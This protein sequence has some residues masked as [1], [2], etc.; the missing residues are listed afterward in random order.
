MLFF[1]L[2]SAK[3]QYISV[4]DTYT[5]QQ[6]VQNVLLNSGCANVSNFSVSGGNFGAENTYGFFNAGSSGFPLSSGVVLSTCRAKSCEGPNNSL[7]SETASGWGGDSDLN[8]ALGLSN[9]YNATVLEFDFVPNSASVSFDYLFASEEYHGTSPCRYSDGFAF[10]LKENGTSSPYQNLAL[11]PGTNT[12]VKVTTVH[13]DIPGGCGAQNQNYFGM[14]NGTNAPI[15]FNGQTVVLTAQASVTPGHS[16]HI[17]LVIADETNPQ[18]DSAIFLGSG[19]FSI[20]GTINLGSDR[21]IANNTALCPGETI[22]IVVPNNATETYQWY[23]DGIA[24]TGETT[25]SININSAGVYSLHITPVG[26]SCFSTGNVRIEYA[27]NPVVNNANFVNCD[28]DNDGI[29]VFNLTNAVSAITLGDAT[30]HAVGYYTSNTDAQNEVNVIP[31]PTNFSN[32]VTN[33]VYVRIENANG[34]FSIATIS[35]AVSNNTVNP[36]STLKCDD[37]TQDGK[38]TFDL[39]VDVLPLFVGLPTGAQIEYYDT[40]NDAYAETNPLPNN[41]TNTIPYQQVIYARITNNSYCYSITSVTLKVDTILGNFNTET[42]LI[43]PNDTAVLQSPLGSSYLWNTG[44]TSQS[45][46]TTTAGSYTVTV[47]SSNG[48]SASK[49]FIIQYENTPIIK[50]IE[51]NDFQDNNS[52]TIVLESSGNYLYSLDNIHYQSS[53]IFYNLQPKAY[54]VYVKSG[55]CTPVSETFYVLNYPK[56]F[57]PNSDGANDFWRIKNLQYFPKTTVTIFDRFGKLL[58]QFDETDTGWNGLY[59]NSQLPSDDYWFTIE[60]SSQKIVK[61]HFAM[62]R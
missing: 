11:I 24:L 7:L 27:Q 40:Q 2:N 32:A 37:T 38:T 9:T 55:N 33:T 6:L 41:F 23:K 59:Q 25:S 8:T 62:K 19:S 35:L 17:K 30:L 36:V 3:A 57:T 45:I 51:I 13:P 28:D 14:Y 44:A 52:A 46:S 16:Y 1:A 26:S 48:C 47:T 54:T 50:D 29:S 21:L 43:C 53:P 5:A 49:T 31:N 56:F 42:F 18:Y 4:D 34:C 39:S 15:N 58:Y 20:G 60:F 61:G 12:P 22:S 10:L